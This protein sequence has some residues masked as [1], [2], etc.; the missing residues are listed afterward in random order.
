MDHEK[1]VNLKRQI[2]E[3]GVKQ[4]LEEAQVPM[5]Y[6]MKVVEKLHKALKTNEKQ[7]KTHKEEIGSIHKHYQGELKGLG[8]QVAGHATNIKDTLDSTVERIDAEH[9][10]VVDEFRQEIERLKAIQEGK[11]GQP[12]KD[13]PPIDEEGLISR[14]LSKVP[15]PEKGD[16]GDTG[17]ALALDDVITAV[18]KRIQKGDVLHINNVKGAGAFIKD[19]IKYRFEELMHGSGSSSGSLSGTQEKSTTIPNGILTS[20]AFAHTPKVIVWNGAVQTK[21]DDYTVSGNSITFTA[22]AGIPQ[23]GDKILNIYG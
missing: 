5:R 14:L 19:G 9:A 11:P 16:K 13:A 10:K 8:E 20:F 3:K 18:V 4:I 21:T 15:A 2:I 22:S 1:A 6:H 12:G 23:T 7:A 17:D